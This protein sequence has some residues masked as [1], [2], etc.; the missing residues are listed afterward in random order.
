MA[1]FNRGKSE[2]NF[3]DGLMENVRIVIGSQ[4]VNNG[5]TMSRLGVMNSSFV[6]LSRCVWVI[7]EPIYARCNVWRAFTIEPLRME[8]TMRRKPRFLIVTS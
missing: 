4:V 8:L 7:G 1:S 6:M 2:V 5:T 3:L